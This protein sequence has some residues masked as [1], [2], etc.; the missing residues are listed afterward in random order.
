V[1]EIAA[2]WA[3]ALQRYVEGLVVTSLQAADEA[4]QVFRR[5]VVERARETEGW[6]QLADNISLWSQDGYLVIGIANQ[7]LAEQAELLEYGDLD[8]APNPL[9][10]TLTN[11][12]QNAAK[13]MTSEV[14][15][16]T[17]PS[18]DVGGPRIKGMRYGA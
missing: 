14:T 11:E 18:M 6:S 16:F 7:D 12:A 10:R 9:F 8:Q 2:G 1:P 5:A 15:R 17:G 13:S 3:D 4:A